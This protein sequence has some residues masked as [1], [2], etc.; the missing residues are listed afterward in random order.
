MLSWIG[1]N[2]ILVECDWFDAGCR[3]TSLYL[4]EVVGGSFPYGRIK[5]VSS[6][7]DDFLDKVL[8]CNEININLGDY[9]LG[10]ILKIH[11]VI[12]NRDYFDACATLEFESIPDADFSK[13]KNSV[14]W[15]LSIDDTI[16][17]LWHGRKVDIRTKTDLP[18][19]L[20]F[21]QANEYDCELLGSLCTAYKKDTIYALGLD[22]LLI[23]D[24]IGIDS[25]GK[26]EPYWVITSKGDTMTPVKDGIG[27]ED[28]HLN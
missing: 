8:N 23:K 5:L 21:I 18:E 19:G 24:L 25:T 17:A 13:K 1:S 16:K 11:G 7:S 14:T 27:T 12:K 10:P 4:D 2:N 20:E 26:Q 28:Y 15:K 9:D 22:N 3:F 6:G